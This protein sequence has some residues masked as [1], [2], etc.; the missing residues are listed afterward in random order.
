M[1]GDQEKIAML[2][3]PQDLLTGYVE[4][5]SLPSMY[6]RIND[7]INNPRMGMNE[8]SRVISEDSG[9][10]ARLLRIVNSAFYGF[11]TKVETISRA[12]T[13][14][15]TQQLRALALATSVMNMFRGI[16]QD[17]V[18]MEL[19]WK[20]SVAC[21]LAARILAAYRKELN[22]EQY[23]TAG[24]LHDI[25]R[26]IL[27]SKVP[28]LARQALVR[29][30]TERELLFVVEREVIGFDHGAMGAALVRNW[31]LPAGFEEVVAFHNN[32]SGAKRYPVET[33]IVHVADIIAHVMQL[34]TTG[35]RFVPPLYR[36][37]WDLIGLS[38]SVLAPTIDQV[39]AQFGETIHHMFPDSTR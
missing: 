23:F 27:Y 36:K 18:N 9:L 33:A 4:I 31:K 12:V 39:D 1:S 29:S 30:R 35:E 8:I 20:H 2:T 7:A 15:G 38:E 10:S 26:L 3:K 13:I 37:A 21:G 19:F 34:G 11:P 17:L 16:P 6:S 14:V 22:T 32:P 28:D 24:I 5:S 25:G